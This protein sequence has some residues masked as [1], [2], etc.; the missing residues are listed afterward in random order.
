M[1]NALA[2]GA[3]TATLR[4]LIA[5][6]LSSEGA[7]AVT[8]LPPDLAK[9]FNGADESGRVNLFLYHAQPNAA[10]RNQDPPRQLK[11][12]ETGQPARVHAHEHGLLVGRREQFDVLDRLRLPRHRLAIQ[13]RA[14]LGRRADLQQLAPV[15]ERR[16]G[17]MKFLEFVALK[18][19][20]HVLPKL[21]R[22]DHGHRRLEAGVEGRL[23]RPGE[24]AAARL[25][26]C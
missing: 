12:G 16:L 21:L 26:R 2:I 13:H 24:R 8:T 23:P 20:P 19:R 14:V 17:D 7:I 11:P 9:T 3:A 15:I 5:R 10:W 25:A 22:A 18:I 1:S 6:G 4:S